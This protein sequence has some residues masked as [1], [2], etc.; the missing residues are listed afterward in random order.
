VPL[1]DRHALSIGFT[2]VAGGAF[3][4]VYAD[5]DAVSDAERLAADIGRELD[6]LA[7]GVPLK[8]RGEAAPVA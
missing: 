6:V 5:R 1:A 8:P 7:R 2:S 4:G 3:F